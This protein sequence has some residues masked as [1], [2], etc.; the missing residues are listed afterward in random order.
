MNRVFLAGGAA[1]AVLLGGLWAARPGEPTRVEVPPGLGARR[2]SELLKREGVV[3]S[4]FA[5]RVLLKVT[6]FERH[7][8]PGSYTLRRHEWPTWCWSVARR[9]CTR[10]C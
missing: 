2:T 5:F 7:L 4:A 9:R 10:R 1:L 6:G 8:K 3:H